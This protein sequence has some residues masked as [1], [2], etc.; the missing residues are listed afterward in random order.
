M[1]LPLRMWRRLKLTVPISPKEI[2]RVILARPQERLPRSGHEGH[3]RKSVK[4]SV[5]E[6]VNHKLGLETTAQQSEERSEEVGEGGTAVQV[7]GGVRRESHQQAS[8]SEWAVL[9][10]G[11]EG[12]LQE[13]SMADAAVVCTH[14]FRGEA[15]PCRGVGPRADGLKRVSAKSAFECHVTLGIDRHRQLPVGRQDCIIDVG[16]DFGVKTPDCGVYCSGTTRRHGE[17][18]FYCP[19]VHRFLAGASILFDLANFGDDD[20]HG[21]VQALRVAAA[22]STPAEST[23]VVLWTIDKAVVCSQ[24]Q[25]AFSGTDA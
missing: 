8:T 23:T 11:V 21:I 9:H 18:R 10:R 16:I 15:P 19:R 13:S 24:M 14:D 22:V 5:L 25:S 1:F 2:V 6:R 17:D 4:K 20:D 3:L 12:V 7:R